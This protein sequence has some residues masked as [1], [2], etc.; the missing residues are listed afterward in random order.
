MKRNQKWAARAAGRM[1]QSMRQNLLIEGYMALIRAWDEQDE[2][3]SRDYMDS[4]REALEEGGFIRETDDI[5]EMPMLGDAP[6]T[7]D[8]RVRRVIART[9]YVPVDI[10]Q[11]MERCHKAGVAL[12]ATLET[13]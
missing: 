10:T 6:G 3:R 13:E 11:Q 2:E 8:V 4:A 7:I 5:W 1:H 9:V 12:R